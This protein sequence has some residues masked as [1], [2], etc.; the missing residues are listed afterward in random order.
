[1]MFGCLEDLS[2]RACALEIVGDENENEMHKYKNIQNSRINNNKS[3]Y[4]NV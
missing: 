1:M 4:N 2:T 3:K